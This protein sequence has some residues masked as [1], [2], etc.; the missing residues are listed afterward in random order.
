MSYKQHHTFIQYNYY[1]NHSLL[2]VIHDCMKAKINYKLS[3]LLSGGVA[4]LVR[5]QDS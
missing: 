4:Q 3:I 1:T 2:F 5:A